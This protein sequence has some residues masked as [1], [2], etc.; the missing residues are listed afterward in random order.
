MHGTNLVYALYMLGTLTLRLSHRS[1]LFAI[2]LAVS[3]RM[4]YFSRRPCGSRTLLTE[5]LPQ[6]TDA[7]PTG[8]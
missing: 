1:V 4:F 5:K 6:T 7:R 2:R 3:I 8:P